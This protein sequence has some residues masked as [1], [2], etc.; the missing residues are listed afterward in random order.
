MY[1]YSDHYVVFQTLFSV[2]LINWITN[3]S[4]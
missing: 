4:R 3:I 2:L 1:M